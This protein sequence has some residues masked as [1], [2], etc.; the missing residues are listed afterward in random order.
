[1]ATLLGCHL[2]K[3]SSENVK[4]IS[5]NFLGVFSMSYY[6]YVRS[7]LSS[8]KG[9]QICKYSRTD[10]IFTFIYYFV[11]IYLYILLPSYS[12][13]RG[14]IKE[15]YNLFMIFLCKKYVYTK[16]GILL[17]KCYAARLIK[18]IKCLS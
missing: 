6:R 2:A 16:L 18:I 10:V 4:R 8:L 15:R 14:I 5:E 12:P 7:T 13:Q 17:Y 1:M 11:F 9:K 3:R